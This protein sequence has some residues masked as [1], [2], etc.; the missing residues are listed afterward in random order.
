MSSL[1]LMNLGSAVMRHY[2]PAMEGDFAAARDSGSPNEA[3]QKLYEHATA[4]IVVVAGIIVA[5]ILFGCGIWWLV[6]SSAGAEEGAARGAS[7]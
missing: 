5:V 1:A 7:P 2:P 4:A 6:V 3:F